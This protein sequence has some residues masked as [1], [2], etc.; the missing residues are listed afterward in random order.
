MQHLKTLKISHF[1]GIVCRDTKDSHNPF[2][3][4]F[5]GVFIY[6]ISHAWPTSLLYVSLLPGRAWAI[7]GENL[8]FFMGFQA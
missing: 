3:K 8:V 7:R 4:N 2:F 1:Q 6:K 5:K